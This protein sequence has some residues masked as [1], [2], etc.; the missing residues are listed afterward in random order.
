MFGQHHFFCVYVQKHIAC[1]EGS[2]HTS[3]EQKV[4]NV[5]SPD[6]FALS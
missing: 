3:S 2:V 1:G 5:V 4:E 6:H